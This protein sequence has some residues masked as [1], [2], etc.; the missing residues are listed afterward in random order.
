MPESPFRCVLDV[1]AK[2]G[3]SPTWS[4]AEQALWFVDITAPALHRF[5]PATGAHAVMPMPSS[6]GCMG[7]RAQGGFVVALRDGLWL[8]DAHGRLERKVA[9]A[10]YD[11]TT[12]AST[13]A[14][15]ILRD[16]SGS[17]R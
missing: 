13:T 1:K 7:L 2:L 4:V 9:Q 17:A 10:P 11:L 14:A 3:E 12:T 16:D 8:A 6:V 15:S 5:D